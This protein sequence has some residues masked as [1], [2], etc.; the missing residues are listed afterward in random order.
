MAR[1]LTEEQCQTEYDRA[2]YRATQDVPGAQAELDALETALH[3]YAKLRDLR[4]A[5]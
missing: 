2:A 1:V 4:V 5:H 3:L